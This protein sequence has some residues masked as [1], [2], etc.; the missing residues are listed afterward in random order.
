MP[1]SPTAR[2]LGPVDPDRTL[3]PDVRPEYPDLARVGAALR[4]WWPALVIGA[5]LFGALGA[6]ASK[7]ATTPYAASAQILVGPL[8]GELSVLRAAGQQA[9]TYAD[10][11]ASRPVYLGTLRRLGL[12]ETTT[13]FGRRVQVDANSATR[14]LRATVRAESPGEAAREANALA[15]EV[16][17]Q[18]AAQQPVLTAAQKAEFAKHPSKKLNPAQAAAEVRLRVVEPAVPPAKTNRGS[19][20]A[21]IGVAGI[22]GALLAA[23]LALV[24]E[25]V[26]RR[27]ETLDELS[28]I[29]PVPTIGRLRHGRVSATTAALSGARDG[30]LVADAGE[31]SAPLA[32][33]LGRSVLHEGGRA[34]IV[35]TD[36]RGRL[37]RY[38]RA[39]NRPGVARAAAH[40]DNIT[41]V[42]LD[43]GDRL[44]VLPRGNIPV[45]PAPLSAEVV[46]AVLSHL[47]SNPGEAVI[48]CTGAAP[49]AT[50]TH[51]AGRAV[52][53][54]GQG[55]ARAGEVVDAVRVLERR[56]WEVIGVVLVEHP[57]VHPIALLRRLIERFGRAGRPM[58]RTA[59][60]AVDHQP[61]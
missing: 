36:P 31:G 47:E 9:Q 21:F 6:Q 55:R 4:R 24:A 57:G 14:L 27:I 20:K 45:P 29:S 16:V 54:V 42:S 56:G 39:G 19:K 53:A 7:P 41:T 13:A 51:G 40:P 30:V 32:L 61:V 50:Q 5:L 58:L 52:L 34:L 43:E 49:H 26:R 28:G 3:D 37:T 10:L 59:P 1:R 38:L 23:A 33:A 15:A 48:V 2:I 11:A 46:D 44:Q 60:D 12:K 8:A 17:R 35:D 22:V 18:S 25:G